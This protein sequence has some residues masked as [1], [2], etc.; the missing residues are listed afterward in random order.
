[1]KTCIVLPSSKIFQAE[2]SH[3]WTA[4]WI[5]HGVALL[6][7]YCKSQGFN[8]DLVDTRRNHDWFNFELAMRRYEVVCFSVNTIDYPI[9]LECLEHLKTVNPLATVIVGGVHPTV[10]LEDFMND[11]RVDYIIQKEGELA[12]VGLL[13]CIRG[14]VR[15]IP[16]VTVGKSVGL[17]LIPYIDRS[18]WL[19]EFPWGLNFS[20]K[21]PFVTILASRACTQNCSFCQPCSKIMFGNEERRRSVDNVIGELVELNKAGF[22]SWMIHDDGFLQNLEW[23]KQFIKGYKE[24][25]GVPRPFIIQSRANYPVQHP[26]IIKELKEIG[27][28]VAIV[29][30]ESGSDD[31]LKIMRKGTTREINL[32]GAE[33]LHKNGIKIFANIMF[34]VPGETLQ[35][36]KDTMSM[37]K[38]IKPEHFS[39]A[40]YSPYPGND[41]H[42]YCQKNKLILNEYA[43]RYP[44]EQ[45][46]KGIQY[47]F[48]QQE[49]DEY[50][51]SQNK[52]KF[53]LKHT[54]LPMA[55]TAR[56][57]FRTVRA[58]VT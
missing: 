49:I 24:T 54:N 33:I 15:D 48:I 26:E 58:K 1:M 20:G 34:G 11:K 39:A 21:E 47:N 6:I 10:K 46:I 18:L 31:V 25:I 23:V 5:N 2:K 42:D 51:R 28:E 37:I 53:W 3:E 38:T 19:P 43:S 56:R 40:T 41:L 35:D 16:R 27:L 52:V 22:N 29:G 50:N 9:Y 44:G 7:S 4:R 45:K 12:L 32:K 55:N 13:H 30:F 17:D 14:G 57:M 8:V 36:V